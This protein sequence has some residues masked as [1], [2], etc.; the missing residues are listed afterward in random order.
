M[1]TTNNQ[2]NNVSLSIVAEELVQLG[3]TKVYIKNFDDSKSKWIARSLKKNL[4]GKYWGFYDT[5]VFEKEEDAIYFK[6]KWSN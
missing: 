6:L 3:W 1:D 5:W 4:T 2:I